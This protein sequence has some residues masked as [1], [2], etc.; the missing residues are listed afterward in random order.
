MELLLFAHQPIKFLK[1]NIKHHDKAVK[2]GEE[3]LLKAFLTP[4]L[5]FGTLLIPIIGSSGIGKSHVIRWLEAKIKRQEDGVNRRIIRIPKSASLK[6]V[7]SL[8]LEGMKGKNYDDLRT[9]LSHSKEQLNELRAKKLLK[10][11]IEIALHEYNIELENKLLARREQGLTIDKIDDLK[12]IHSSEKGLPTIIND[13]EFGKHFMEGSLSRIAKRFI[14]GLSE[15]EEAKTQFNENDLTF[16]N[17]DFHEAAPLASNYYKLINRTGKPELRE[18]A[19]SVLNEVVDT[20]LNQLFEKESNTSITNIF[21]DIREN[22]LKEGIELILLVEDFAVI[23]G[24]QRVLLDIIIQ[25]GIYNDKQVRCPMRTALAVTEGYLSNRDTVLTRAVDEWIIE[26]VPFENDTQTLDHI[27][28]FIGG[29]LNAARYG[30]EE[31]EKMHTSSI[32]RKSNK[33]IINYSDNNWDSSCLDVLDKFGKSKVEHHLFPYNKNSIAVLAEDYLRNSSG[34]LEFNPR[35][36]I[37]NILRSILIDY[38]EDFKNANFPPPN[39]YNAK[40]RYDVQQKIINKCT[41]PVLQKRYI[42]LLKYWG[43]DPTSI[44]DTENIP[45]EVYEVFSLKPIF[46]WDGETPL[47]PDI[48]LE[49]PQ[50]PTSVTSVE[51]RK[52][53]EFVNTLDKWASGSS[54]PQIDA[55]QIRNWLKIAIKKYID[56]DKELLFP[57]DLKQK[58]IY[59]PNSRGGFSKEKSIIIIAEDNVHENHQDSTFL[60]SDLMALIKFNIYGDWHYENSE[61]DIVRYANFIEKLSRQA[62][63][64]FQNNYEY[65]VGDTTRI[66]ARASLIQARILDIEKSQNQDSASLLF[67]M[68]SDTEKKIQNQN[69]NRWEKLQ[70]NCSDNRTDLLEVLKKQVAARQGGGKTVHAVDGLRLLDS[71]NKQFKETYYLDEEIPVFPPEFQ[72]LKNHLKELTKSNLDSATK[73]LRKSLTIWLDKLKKYL[74]ENIEKNE[75]IETMKTTLSLVKKEGVYEGRREYDTLRNK[76]LTFLRDSPFIENLNTVKDILL[77]DKFSKV[78]ANLSKIDMEVITKVE[79]IFDYYDEFLESTNEALKKK[80]DVMDGEGIQELVKAIDTELNNLEK[81]LNRINHGE[82]K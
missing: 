34:K 5:P 55:N 20:A 19:I 63:L 22:L 37:N 67:A 33:W 4:H 54:L 77:E 39:F 45:P 26:D 24:I 64:Y 38:R 3:D 70:M 11:E 25:E 51:E 41:D 72:N 79:L 47:E 42:S 56:W 69:L 66:L 9:K 58:L 48:D 36:I 31:I 1:R 76:D 17:F 68:F 46:G 40:L 82:S 75:I 49:L 21:S 74:G 53:E 50:K 80:M 60:L 43:G 32:K 59:M 71:I 18:S 52:V 8:I 30:K 61:K 12:R 10:A 65:I 27:T 81:I 14:D 7:I 6:H 29:Y 35:V 16:T 78:L 15:G 62:I 28:N 2:C 13:I 44:V 73:E 23:A 57:L